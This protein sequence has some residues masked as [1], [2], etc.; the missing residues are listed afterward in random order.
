MIAKIILNG[1]PYLDKISEEDC[2]V[3]ACDKGY[4]YCLKK[5]I[6]PTY[7]VGDFDSLNYEP[8]DCI[9]YPVD[10][11][12]TD[13]EGALDLLKK[14]GA[15]VE[16]IEF[17]NFGGGRD[18]HFLG[19]LSLLIKA[20]NLGFF[21]VA[22]TNYT[23]IYYTKNNFSLRN[24]KNKTISLVPYL[25]EVNINKGEGFKYDPTGKKL[26]PQNTLG[27]SNVAKDNDISLDFDGEGLFIFVVK[28]E[29]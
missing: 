13:G 15:D 4:E 18:D 9:K 1:E 11:D 28:G 14:V 20:N 17:Y 3:I 12:F 8:K 26:S 10:K 16:V 2:I 7:V 22:K 24:V 19:N 27:I 25:G 5:G 21:S 29:I 23:D 6:K